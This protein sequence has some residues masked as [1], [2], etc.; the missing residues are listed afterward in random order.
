MK[1]PNPGSDKAI[2]GGCTCPALDNEHG[3]G[4]HGNPE[5]FVYVE[6]C[7]MHAMPLP[8]CSSCGVEEKNPDALLSFPEG[9]GPAHEACIE[10]DRHASFD[11]ST[12]E[13]RW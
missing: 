12:L 3:R 7:S 6:G 11:R 4:Y 9:N 1:K 13:G 5:I 10:A 2:D 8:V